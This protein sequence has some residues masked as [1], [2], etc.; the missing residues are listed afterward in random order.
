MAGILTISP[1]CSPFPYGPVAIATYTQKAEL[2][3]DQSALRVTLDLN[4]SKI[5]EEDEIVQALAKA[6]GLS[7]DSAKVRVSLWVR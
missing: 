5:T 1:T 7:D 6:G 4:G 3:F 2:V